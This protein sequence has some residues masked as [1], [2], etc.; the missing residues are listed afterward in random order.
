MKS[1]RFQIQKLEELK[2]TW[3]RIWARI[4]WWTKETLTLFFF[5]SNKRETQQDFDFCF[6]E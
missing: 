1:L 5:C 6:N 3:Q 4:R 2:A